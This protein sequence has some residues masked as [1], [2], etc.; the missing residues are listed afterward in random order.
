M[1]RLAGAARSQGLYGLLREREEL[2]DL[3]HGGVVHSGQRGW[4]RGV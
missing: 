4:E 3:E 1:A 2:K